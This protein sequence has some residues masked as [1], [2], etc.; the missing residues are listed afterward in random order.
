MLFEAVIERGWRCNWRPR[1]S[2]LRDELGGYD[3]A[4]LEENLEAVDLEGGATAA[5]TLAGSGKLAGSG[6]LWILG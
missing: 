6:I 4:R 1:L 3:R 2:E 5:E